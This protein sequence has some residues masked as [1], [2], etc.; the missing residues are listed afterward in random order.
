MYT[1][2]ADSFYK[3]KRWEAMRAAVLRRDGYLCQVSKRYGKRVAA[4]T[5]HHIFPRDIYPEYQWQPWNLISLSASVH[6]EMHDRQ[7]GAL[8]D[9]GIALLKR[10]ARYWGVTIP[11]RYQ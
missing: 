9:K 3:S 11:L 8:T 6:D 5:V 4:D 10:T 2:R 1:K 7:T